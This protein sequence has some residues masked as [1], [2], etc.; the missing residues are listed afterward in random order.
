MRERL[1]NIMW[2]DV[3]VLHDAQSLARGPAALDALARDIADCGVA[4]TAAA[5]T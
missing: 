4:D 2:N 3:G 5:T 1:Y